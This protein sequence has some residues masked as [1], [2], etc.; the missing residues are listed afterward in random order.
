VGAGD[1]QYVAAL[2]NLRRQP[3]GATGVGRARVKDGFHEGKLRLAVGTPAAADDVADHKHVGPQR[4]LVGI[5]TF[6]QFDAQSPQLVAH[7]GVD[8][9]VT[10]GDRVAG[11]PREGGKPAHE[12]AT[13][14]KNMNVHGPILGLPG[15]VRRVGA[16]PWQPN[17]PPIAVLVHFEVMPSVER[18]SDAMKN[19]VVVGLSMNILL[20]EMR[21][22]PSLVRSVIK[23]RRAVCG[24][25]RC[26]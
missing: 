10:A 12:G 23:K 6:D 8:A 22:S 3:L 1:C 15:I 7:R 9:R 5:K 18:S 16:A 4:H 13:D 25:T 21:I 14:A 24:L 26:P 20:P 2:Q 17:R 11:L 19:K